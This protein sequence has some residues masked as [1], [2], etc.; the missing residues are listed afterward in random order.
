RN[1]L[2]QA[3]GLLGSRQLDGTVLQAM[4]VN[5]PKSG[6]T[7]DKLCDTGR[8]EEE[9]TSEFEF[10]TG[11]LLEILALQGK[12]VGLALARS[13]ANSLRRFQISGPQLGLDKRAIVDVIVDVDRVI[14]RNPSP[15]TEQDIYLLKDRFEIGYRLGANFGIYKDFIYTRAFTLVYPVRSVHESE[16]DNGFIVNALLP[17]HLRNG[18]VPENFVLM[19]EHYFESGAGIQI[20]NP[21]L[22]ISPVLIVGGSRIRLW[23][24]IFDHRDPSHYTLY[25]DRSDFLQTKLE[26][27]LRVFIF[28]LPVFKS[29][30][31]WGTATGRGSVFTAA[32]LASKEG[33]DSI[34]AAMVDGDFRRIEPRERQF[35]LTNTFSAKERHWKFLFWGGTRTRE[36]DQ[37]VLKSPEAVRTG[38]QFKTMSESD[39]N[40]LGNREQKSASVETFTD[41]KKPGQ[42][43]LNVRVMSYDAATQEKHLEH[44]YLSFINGLSVTG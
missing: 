14:E 23:R 33:N 37:I 30:H 34:V 7:I 44:R 13:A 2:L 10:D 1:D 24:S 18:N 5:G 6:L 38:I 12:S 17:I 43:Q 8:I 28:K 36:L 3:L 41:A 29:L 15:K 4:T 42:Y 26:A 39:R 21:E 22:L 11:R 20:E 27:L 40:I 32:E 25:R 35:D 16:L 31:S 9:F 19:T